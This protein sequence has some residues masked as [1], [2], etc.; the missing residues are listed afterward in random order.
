MS[1]FLLFSCTFLV[2]VTCS[3]S[4]LGRMCAF[5]CVEKDSDRHAVVTFQEDRL[6]LL[7]V[8]VP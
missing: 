5:L 1:S 8:E 3:L 7:L 6:R 4:V 2:V